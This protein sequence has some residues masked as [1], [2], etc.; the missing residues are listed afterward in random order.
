[1]KTRVG[2]VRWS[3]RWMLHWFC[4]LVG[5]GNWD[6]FSWHSTAVALTLRSSSS[7]PCYVVASTVIE[8]A[9]KYQHSMMS[10]QVPLQDM[11]ANVMQFASP[12]L[13]MQLQNRQIHLAQQ[14]I[15]RGHRTGLL[16]YPCI[17]SNCFEFVSIYRQ[18]ARISWL[19][20]R[21]EF[22]NK[23]WNILCQQFYDSWIS[24]ILSV[25]LISI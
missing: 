7:S 21:S 11:D 12:T 15:A 10:L 13:Q 20:S 24:R 16:C 9:P 25:Y 22:L 19:L 18:L 3:A 17:I 6:L 2:I 4:L 23:I 14:E 8:I 1:M 5:I